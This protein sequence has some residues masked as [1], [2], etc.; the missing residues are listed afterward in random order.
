ML[1]AHQDEVGVY[2]DNVNGR[3]VAPELRHAYPPGSIAVLA[4]CVTAKP[5]SGMDILNG[6]ND[7]GIDAMI[8][9]PFNVRLDY[10]SRMAFEFAKAVRDNRAK[11]RTPTLAEMFAQATAATGQFSRRKTA[12]PGSG[13]WPSS[14]SW[15]VTRI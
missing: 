2:F 5:N 4:A 15:S 12:T 11:R 1:L 7:N 10:G 8:V 14:S 9:S 6:L 13:K 3:V